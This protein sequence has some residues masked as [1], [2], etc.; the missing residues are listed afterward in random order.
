M[1]LLWQDVSLVDSPSMQ[2]RGANSNV[3]KDCLQVALL[4]DLRPFCP[5]DVPDVVWYSSVLTSPHSLTE[6]S[7]RSPDPFPG[8]L[9]VKTC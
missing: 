4:P 9:L 3:H 8:G 6:T 7:D 5:P 2:T 1:Q